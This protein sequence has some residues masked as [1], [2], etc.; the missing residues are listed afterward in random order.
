MRIIKFPDIT[1]TPD[2][3]W[4]TPFRGKNLQLFFVVPGH[5]AFGSAMQEAEIFAAMSG[6]E[7][8]TQPMRVRDAKTEYARQSQEDKPSTQLN[9]IES[10]ELE[11]TTLI[12]RQTKDGSFTHKAQ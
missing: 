9:L 4:C 1:G 11:G 8:L 12:A 6:I 5:N 7:A 3:H 2:D 10:I